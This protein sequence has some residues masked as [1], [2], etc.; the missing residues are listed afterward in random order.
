M[1]CSLS[2]ITG[3]ISRATGAA[4]VYRYDGGT[5]TEEIKVAGENLVAKIKELVQEGNINRIIIKD[6]EGNTFIEVPL[7]V[8][9]VGILL[10]PVWAAIGAIAALAADF[11]IVVERT[12][13]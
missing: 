8:G 2:S 12:G 7:T 3:V 11:T 5:W 6:T 9:V 13:E 1:S 10:L 4:Y